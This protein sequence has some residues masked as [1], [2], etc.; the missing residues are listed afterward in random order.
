MG[1]L[2]PEKFEIPTRPFNVVCVDFIAPTMVR[3]S[4][5]Q[6]TQKKVF[7]VLYTCLH[8][9]A[10]HPVVCEDYST[11]GF[12]KKFNT[13]I[14]I[15]GEPRT[16]ITDLGSQLTKAGKMTGGETL[17][18]SV[19]WKEVQSK[20]AS[21]GIQWIHAPSGGQWRNGKAEAMVKMLKKS[22]KHLQDT[23]EL[24]LSEYEDLLFRA[25]CVINSRPLGVR[26]H[27]GAEPDVHVITPNLMLMGSR[28]DNGPTDVTSYEEDNSIHTRR[29]R[30]VE[31][32]Y[33]EWWKLWYVD[34][35]PHL[36]PV[37]KWRTKYPN[38]SKGD[39]VLVFYP[40]KLGPGE[41]RYGRVSATKPDEKGIVRTVEVSMRP[42]DS[43]EPVLPYKSKKLIQVELPVQRLVLLHP[44]AE[45]HKVETPVLDLSDPNALAEG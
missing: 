19:R 3:C 13:F 16:I 23:Y 39:I 41:Y 31:R 42:R 4:V 7:P 27:G 10:L 18:N 15:R 37:A 29:L 34:V 36:I 26:H 2:P 9:E 32:M 24:T 6:R 12:L 22:L 11:Q 20:A 17:E 8:T 44:A 35:F 1:Q 38:L 28:G 45:L 21:Q 43:R 40:K 30:F 33:L 5:K 14:S 25:A